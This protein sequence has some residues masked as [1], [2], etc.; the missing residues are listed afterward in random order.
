[1]CSHKCDALKPCAG[2]STPPTAPATSMHAP[3]AASPAN[4][5]A[6]RAIQAGISSITAT[7]ELLRG[8]Q[9]HFLA[10]LHSMEGQMRHA[11]ET[12][13]SMRGDSATPAHSPSRAPSAADAA[14]YVVNSDAPDSARQRVSTWMETS[15]RQKDDVPFEEARPGATAAPGNCHAN[16]SSDAAPPVARR[17]FGAHNVAM[18]AAAPCDSPQTDRIT[19]AEGMQQAHKRQQSLFDSVM[20][21]AEKQKALA[22]AM[23]AS[24]STSRSGT[25]AWA[26]CL[27]EN[28]HPNS[29]QHAQHAMRSSKC[30][31]PKPVAKDAAAKDAGEAT[32]AASWQHELAS[33]TSAQH[34]LVNA[35]Q[36]D[37]S[38]T[39][40]R[41]AAAK[42]ELD[43]LQAE[44]DLL[45][46]QVRASLCILSICSL[47]SMCANSRCI[48]TGF[49]SN[50]NCQE[51]AA[52]RSSSSNRMHRA[53]LCRPRV[54]R[55]AWHKL[56]SNAM[57]LQRS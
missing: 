41:V 47:M 5:L 13:Q 32:P 45:R 7:N 6:G 2:T 33:A 56:C 34:D 44:L 14:N 50:G 38:S 54:S 25:P 30:P 43:M 46:Q 27:S 16:N 21:E 49:Q 18:P 39:G 52:G 37:F 1:M 17:I 31:E 4:E 51:G 28:S 15:L 19:T 22:Q 48:S 57:L 12:A 26:A 23:L 11:R 10:Q 29:P 9:Q 40:E 42:L 55:Q 53:P 3:I 35:L 20:Q 24:V 8:F 36:A